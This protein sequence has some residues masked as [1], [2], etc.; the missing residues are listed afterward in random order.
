MTNHFRGYARSSDRSRISQTG[1]RG[2]V[3]AGVWGREGVVANPRGYQTIIY[4]NVAESY[5]NM[6]KTGDSLLHKTI[7]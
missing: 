2:G 6:K 4:P 1:W 7:R 5:M 3:G